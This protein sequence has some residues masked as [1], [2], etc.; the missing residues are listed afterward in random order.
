MHSCT[1]TANALSAQGCTHLTTRLSTSMRSSSLISM[2]RP[3][4]AWLCIADTRRRSIR[5]AIP[6]ILEQKKAA[7]GSGKKERVSP[8]CSCPQHASIG[9]MYRDKTGRDAPS[10][11]AAICVLADRQA[12]QGNIRA[13]GSST[14]AFPGRVRR[15]REKTVAGR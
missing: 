6:K 1:N 2:L 14:R 12:C 4:I 5:R 3:G 9:L 15:P 10:N 8:H 7:V 11:R 13:A